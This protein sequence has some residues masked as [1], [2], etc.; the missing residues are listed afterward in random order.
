[1]QISPSSDRNAWV[2]RPSASASRASSD[3]GITSRGLR[4]RRCQDR[5][6]QTAGQSLVEFALVLPLVLILFLAIADFA[7]L[8]ATMIA[9]ESAAR[10]SADF[11]TLYP[12]QWE[13]TAIPVTEA[14]MERRA[15]VAAK[16][17]PDYLGPD[18]ACA[19]PS[20]D[21]DL[22]PPAGV[23]EA[24][25]WLVPRTSTPCRVEVTLG[26][27]FDLIVPLSIQFFNTELGIPTQLSFERT[28]VFA[29]SDFAVDQPVPTP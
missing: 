9:I 20:F 21:Y 24:D 11:G 1:M 25:C 3:R 5:D 12:W 13:P 19:N 7:R 28:S 27:T 2:R 8:Y 10:E 15:C 18:N 4:A 26:Y 23:A 6:P 22:V 29:I 14:E 16:N 17:L